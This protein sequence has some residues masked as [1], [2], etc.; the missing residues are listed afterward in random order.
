[1]HQ[2][3]SIEVDPFKS[4]FKAREDVCG[5]RIKLTTFSKYTM[6]GPIKL[7]GGR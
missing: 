6:L 4:L 5:K 2:P 1:M 3:F 7:T